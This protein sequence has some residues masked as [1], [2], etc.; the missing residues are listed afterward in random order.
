MV[1]YVAKSEECNNKAEI[2]ANSGWNNFI[3]PVSNYGV[4][5][6]DD[7]EFYQKAAA[8]FKIAKNCKQIHTLLKICLCS[9][10]FFT[11]HACF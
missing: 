2:V 5:E 7:A 3:S 6:Y 10:F 4:D 8:S 11:N 1:D 9:S